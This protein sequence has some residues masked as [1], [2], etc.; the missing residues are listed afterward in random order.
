M[1]FPAPIPVADADTANLHR[2]TA[3]RSQLHGRLGLG[4]VIPDKAPW[5]N[6]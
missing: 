5:H 4:H 1:R 3:G 6:E 2:L